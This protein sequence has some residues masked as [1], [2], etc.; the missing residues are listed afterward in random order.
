M[1][2]SGACPASYF[3]GGE[4]SIRRSFVQQVEKSYPRLM[5]H[6]STC[7][8]PQGMMGTLIKTYFARK[9]G[10][11]PDRI[12][13]RSKHYR[14]CFR[15][16]LSHCLVQ[17]TVSIMP[18]VA[19]KDEIARPQLSMEMDGTDGQRKRIQETDYVLTTRELAHFIQRQK[20]GEGQALWWISWLHLCACGICDS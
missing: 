3:K 8:S 10:V 16:H 14:F 4:L 18:C 19:K 20:V 6:L 9:L 5:P 13:R 12:V 17:V 15:F 2:Q 7:K 11:S 1:D